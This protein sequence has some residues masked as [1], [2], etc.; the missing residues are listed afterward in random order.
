MQEKQKKY[1]SPDEMRRKIE[2]YC[3]YQ[4]RCQQEV[5]N[6]LYE[7]GGYTKDIEQLIAELIEKNFLNEERFAKAYAGGKFRIKHWGKI[8]II[9]ALKFRYISDYCIKIALRQIDEDDYLL[10][11]Q[12]LIEK[13]NPNYLHCTPMQ[14]QSIAK[15]AMSKGFEPNLI[16]NVLN[17]KEK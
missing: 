8:K 15:Y 9:Q 5:R 7:L 1:I 12:Q 17:K 10:T 16:W 6:K 14:K 4:E 11:L 3:A 2:H 13:K